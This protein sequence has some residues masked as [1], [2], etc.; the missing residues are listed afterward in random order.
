MVLLFIDVIGH[1]GRVGEYACMRDP[2][3]RV[4]FIN[5][6]M[7]RI[8]RKSKLCGFGFSTASGRFFRCVLSPPPPKPVHPVQTFISQLSDGIDSIISKHSDFILIVAGDFNSLCTDFIT[9]D[10][11]LYQ[12]AKSP[13]HGDNI[14]DKGFCQYA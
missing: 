12:L 9:N 11:G 3:F 13:T 1:E 2:P 5:L 4:A 7:S 6:L 8:A 14:L 10:C